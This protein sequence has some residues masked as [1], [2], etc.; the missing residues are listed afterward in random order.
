MSIT[1]TEAYNSGYAEIQHDGTRTYHRT[2]YADTSSR[3][4]MK[5]VALADG[6]PRLGTAYSY[7]GDSDPDCIVMKV[8]PVRNPDNEMLWTIDVE[9]S[10][11]PAPEKP[12]QNNKTGVDPTT[13]Q[14][15]SNIA[16]IQF[17]LVPYR[18]A[19]DREQG[20]A[21]KL[22]RNSVGQRFERVPE[23]DDHRLVCRIRR[24]ELEYSPARAMA[25]KDAVNP[26]VCFGG[27]GKRKAKLSGYSGVRDKQ[28][29]F[30]VTDEDAPHP[31]YSIGW[32]VSYEIQF[33]PDTWDLLILNEGFYKSSSAL[34][35][36]TAVVAPT[37]LLRLVDANGVPLNRPAILG[38]DGQPLATGTDPSEGNGG[39]LRFRGYRER[40]F[41]RA[42][43][44]P[45]LVISFDAWGAELGD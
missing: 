17:D 33:D 19:L 23:I 34:S 12:D 24:W 3:L 45:P 14:L 40:E 16:E 38:S 13:G 36:S 32:M 10:R 39:L 35:G 30:Q 29:I 37:D 25:Y 1:I 43:K 44:L 7:L 4:G 20:G 41:E 22:I 9:Y 28:G 27:V 18:K 21:Q 15:S 2:F 26:Q 8:H 5:A 42:L 6:V 11:V 31:K